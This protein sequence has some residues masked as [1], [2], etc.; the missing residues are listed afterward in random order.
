M[1]ASCWLDERQGSSSCSEPMRG[2]KIETEGRGSWN[3][4]VQFCL[5]AQSCLTLCNP[6][7]CSMP[8]FPVHHQLT[9]PT[10]THVHHVGDAIQPSH[11]LSFPF[12]SRLQSFLASGSFPMSQFFT[13]GSQ[14]IGVSVSTSVLPMNIQACLISFRTDLLDLL[15]VQG[16]SPAPQFKSINSLVLKLFY[17]TTLTSIHDY[18]KNHSFD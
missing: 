5:F 17:S 16:S 18:W 4:G 11:P 12:S 9:E 8:G 1:L 7:D 2:A 10:Q 3:A 13:S 6:M 15:A 14:S